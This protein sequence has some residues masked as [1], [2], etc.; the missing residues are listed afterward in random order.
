MKL[1]T[2]Y[3]LATSPL[4]SFA[5]ASVF[6]LLPRWRRWNSLGRMVLGILCATS[7]ANNN[8]VGLCRSDRVYLV[9]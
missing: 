9:I 6:D 7:G 4:L 5:A 1:V 3:I 2:L 8:R